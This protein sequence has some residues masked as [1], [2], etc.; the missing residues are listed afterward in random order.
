MQKMTPM[1]GVPKNASVTVDCIYK[2]GFTWL[3]IKKPPYVLLVLRPDH[4]GL[5]EAFSRHSVNAFAYFVDP[6]TIHD[7]THY[8]PRWAK[9]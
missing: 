7:R 4:V 5:V 3:D 2:S 8:F 6:S 9:Q 1:K